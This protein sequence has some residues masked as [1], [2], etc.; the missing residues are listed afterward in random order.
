MRSV[1][2]GIACVAG[3]L[4]AEGVL[5]LVTPVA[6]VDHTPLVR[7]E[8]HDRFGYRLKASQRAYSYAAPVVTNWE[9]LRATAT[10]SLSRASIVFLGGSETFGKGVLQ[11]DTFAERVGQLTCSAVINAGQPDWTI[12]QSVAWWT[13]HQPQ[14]SARMAVL[15]IAWDDVFSGLPSPG[16]TPQPVWWPRRKYVEWQLD[17]TLAPWLT[18]S[19][20][21]YATKH[22][23]KQVVHRARSSAIYRWQAAWQSDDPLPADLQAALRRTEKQLAR[24]VQH[25]EVLK[26]LV[27][28][29]LAEDLDRPNSRFADHM[30]AMA[31]RV[32]LPARSAH[33]SWSEAQDVLIPWDGRPNG[34]GHRS[35]AELVSTST[36]P[37]LVP[38][39]CPGSER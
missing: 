25:D 1:R 31:K 28:L 30:M 36:R 24:W 10:T 2:W 21:F 8:P 12:E 39:S 19:R 5:R 17:E 34:A 33:A 32:G 38:R 27:V 20:L 26:L 9:G 22:V 6:P 13:V 3:L 4:A 15:T 14:L 29:P 37:E 7:V 16:Y 35:L 11:D 23:A 18:R